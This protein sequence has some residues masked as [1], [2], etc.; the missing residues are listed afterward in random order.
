VKC[1][2]PEPV[3]RLRRLPS[4]FLAGIARL[5]AAPAAGILAAAPRAGGGRAGGPASRLRRSLRAST[6]EGLGAE[7]VAAF[8]GPTVLAGWALHLGATPLEVGMLG[9]LPQLAQLAQFPSALATSALGRRRVA[10]AAVGLSRQ[11]LL[12]LAL[13]PLLGLGGAGARTLLLG[14]A[15]AAA[16]LGV[17][18]N[19]AW[20]AWMGEL[21]PESMRGRFFGRRTAL[22]TVGGT[23]AGVGVAHLLDTAASRGTA[24]LALSLLAGASCLLGLL[25]TVLMSRQHDPPGAPAPRPTL[26]AA[27]RPVR[28][29]EARGLLAYQLAWNAS[30]G[31]GGGFFT[32]HLLHNLRAGFTVAAFHAAASAGARI[33]A[34]PAWG[35]ALDRFGA[36]PVLAACSFAA[37]GLPLV[38]LATAPGRLWPIAIDA[39]VGGM[40]WSGHGLATFSLP[41]SVAPRRDR[42]FYLAAFAMAGGTA[43]A[44]ATWAG[45]GLCAALPR[46]VATLGAVG[47]H[48]LELVFA[49][50]AAGRFASAF[51]SLRIAEEGAGTLTE[52][53]R[54]AQ[55]AA[56]GALAEVRVRARVA[57]GR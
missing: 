25:T 4:S 44:L 29:P 32:F 55:G 41:L 9:A 40:A 11:A 14:V 52:L 23:A 21:V 46:A 36:R 33:L 38:W 19:N 7:L 26:A 57:A 10:I 42:P 51:L 24:D 43:Y 53:H 18:G 22:C 50:S 20:T 47:G 31:L 49:L 39:L 5:A 48:G 56:L 28:D 13:L 16:V 12:P 17:L 37:A 45:G 27:L 1:R 30:V 2:A 35:K 54:A 15:A 34:A 3:R 6:A 8:A